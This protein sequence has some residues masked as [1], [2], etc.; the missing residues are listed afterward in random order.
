MSATAPARIRFRRAND[1]DVVARPVDGEVVV[2]V[3]GEVDLAAAPRLWQVI[4]A[5]L[6]DPGGRLV[7]DLAETTF[8]DS[9]ALGVLVRALKRLR[10]HGGDLVL[11]HPS[12]NARRVFHLTGLDLIL[13]IE[14]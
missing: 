9:S 11:R 7:V 4:E 1:F 5:A 6:P 10:H 12:R 8:L 13:T 3:L 2:F 14:D